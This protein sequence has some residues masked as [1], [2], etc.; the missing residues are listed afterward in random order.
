ML[1]EKT[2]ILTIAFL[3]KI[4]IASGHWRENWSMKNPT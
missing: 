2:F 4:R 1:K 3:P